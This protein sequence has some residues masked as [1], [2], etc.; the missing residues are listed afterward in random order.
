MPSSSSQAFVQKPT[1]VLAVLAASVVA[2]FDPSWLTGPVAELA[3]GQGLR[4]E[5]IS[6][7]K[8][9]LLGRLE[10]LLKRAS[11]RGR[12]PICPEAAAGNGDRVRV[13][14]SLLAVAAEIL[15]TFKVTKPALQ[16][17]LV[18]ARDRLKRTFGLSHARFCQLLGLPERTVRYW[19]K[20]KSK[21]PRG[22][23]NEPPKHSKPRNE[24]RFDL[25]ITLPGIQ[26]AADT[27]DWS[28]F[29]IPLKIIACQ[30][31]GNR[32][33][34]L[35]NAFALEDHE[36]HEIVCQVVEQALGEK[37]GTQLI[38][39]QGT[40]Y[41]AHEA[42]RCYEEMELDHAPQKEGA[43]TDK[44]TLERS[45]RTVKEAVGPLR[46]FFDR[47]G[48]LVP[49][50]KSV[51]CARAI[52]GLLLGVYLQVYRV[53]ER[54]STVEYSRD[55][56]VLEAIAEDQRERARADSRSVKLALERI[57]EEYQLE[58]SKTKFVRSLRGHHVNDI[59]EAERR[60]R[61]KACRCVAKKCDRYFVGI[62]R[63]VAEESRIAR[64][65]RARELRQLS[66]LRDDARKQAEL[67]TLFHEEP[68]HGVASALDLL[69]A[70]YNPTTEQLVQGG[71]GLGRG[72]LIHSLQILKEH[73]PTSSWD[74]AQVGWNLWRK[75]SDAPTAAATVIRT[76]FDR[77]VQEIL[78]T[79]PTT[80][81]ADAIAAILGNCPANETNGARVKSSL[82]R[83]YPARSE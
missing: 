36:D 3:R 43:A 19:A 9:R 27:S 50:L 63:R 65:R 5:R 75:E 79:Q 55:R 71:R 44:A 18:A 78:D 7:L 67:Q 60:L 80:S 20:R 46:R 47:L 32:H 10:A 8:G 82:L 53:A 38:T 64:S 40:P 62:L 48:D 54:K 13:L 11:R 49:A 35:W 59:L 29:G 70:Q 34:E 30:D 45:F 31:P 72:R 52:G 69:E 42:Q 57:H 26:T 16:D 41:L 61:S 25:D 39:D 76:L 2:S 23:K 83:N 37:P 77:T 56:D 22:K 81:T 28:L 17:R 33:R 74:R 6:R 66:R 51:D 15:N 68:E 21:P 58:G 4:A 73:F 24:G 1:P 12:K 14:E